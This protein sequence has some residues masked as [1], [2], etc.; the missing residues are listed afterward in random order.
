MGAVQETRIRFARR[1]DL[2]Y[3]RNERG[4]IPPERMERKIEGKEFIVAERAGA[5]VGLLDLEFIQPEE[6]YMSLIRVDARHR[7]EGIGTALLAFA[8][9]H[10]RGLGFRVLYT[11]S[12]SDEPEPQ[13]W[14]RRSGFEP[15]GA[16]E[17][18][19]GGGIAEVFFRKRL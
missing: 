16:L 10:L 9:E 5:Q 17:D 7:R 15:C 12:Q 8:E 14:H 2:A 4:E 13:A 1:G 6:P 11:S 18:F 19:N 3:L